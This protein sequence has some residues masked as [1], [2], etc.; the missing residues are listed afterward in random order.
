MDEPVVAEGTAR[1]LVVTADAGFAEDLRALLPASPG[2]RHAAD[3]ARAVA[4]ILREP[5][6][7]ILLDA[8]LEPFFA[9]SGWLEAEG[10]LQ[11]LR[12]RLGIRVPVLV[13]SARVEAPDP[14]EP[15]RYDVAAWLPKPPSLT[16]LL[17]ALEA[18]R[19][20]DRGHEQSR[21]VQPGA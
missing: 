12:A 1:L 18:V 9:D 15:E 21:P 8:D 7:C 16:C 2:V 20:R 14:A 5:P 17:A 3:T 6:D 11:I 10:F 13:T 19:S 4:E